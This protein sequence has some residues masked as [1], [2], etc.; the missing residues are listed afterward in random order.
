MPRRYS[1]PAEASCTLMATPASA[2]ST[3]PRGQATTHRWS[4]W[5]AVR[6]KFYDVHHAVASATALEAMQRI[7]A[8]FA[9]ESHIL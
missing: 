6:R 2:N 7:A 1:V 9:I 4:R 8:L 5:P 3:N